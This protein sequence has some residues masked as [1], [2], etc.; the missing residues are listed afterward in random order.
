[1]YLYICLYRMG[2]AG[3]SGE[4]SL[5]RYVQKGVA[6]VLACWWKMYGSPQG[7]PWAPQKRVSPP[8]CGQKGCPPLSPHSDV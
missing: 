4:F 6:R 7:K 1:M 2:R 3:R 8:Q 5:N